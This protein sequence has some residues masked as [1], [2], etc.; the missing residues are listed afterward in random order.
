LLA[1]SVVLIGGL[2][3]LN[4]GLTRYNNRIIEENRSLQKQAES[5]KVTISQFAIVI[6]HNLDLGLRSYALYRDEKYL[7]PMK[8]ALE[9]KD[10]IMG[11]AEKVIRDQHYPMAEFYEL[12]DSI[13]SYAALCV[14]MLQLFRQNNLV[15]FNRISDL[16]KGYLLWLQYE[17]F[18]RKVNQFEDQINEEA[19]V[20]YHAAMRN[21]YIIQILLLLICVPTLVFTALHTSSKFTYEVRLRQSEEEK[22]NLL[23]SQNKLLEQAVLERTQEIQLKSKALQ[24]HVEEIYSQNEEIMAQNDEL[25]RHRT[26]LALQNELLANS[27]KQQLELYKQSLMEK[28]D[29]INRIS[30][31]LEALRGTFTPEL[32]QIQKFNNILHSSILTDEDWER[33]KKTFQEVYPNFFAT[34]R[35]RFPSITASELRLSALIKM[36]LTLKEAAAMLAISASSVKKSRYRLKIRLGLRDEESLEEFIRSVV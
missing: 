23:A 36:N 5:I 33:F 18:A 4:I 8:F 19:Q 17:R 10:S 30:A 6:I 3:I 11:I 25:N 26:E 15:E 34:L 14:K 21:N 29:M 9:D 7:F 31:E 27:K 28:S 22:A 13:N 1:L 35:F 24:K 32:A 2:L 20:R 12:R 16:D